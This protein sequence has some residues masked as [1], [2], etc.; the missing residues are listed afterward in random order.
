MLSTVV[1]AGIAVPAGMK[2]SGR[3]PL[4]TKRPPLVAVALVVA[5]TT[6]R[7]SITYGVPPASV[8]GDESS[9]SDVFEPIAVISYQVEICVE[10]VEPNPMRFPTH[11]P[12]VCHVVPVPVTVVP[13]TATV[14]AVCL[15]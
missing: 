7:S 8:P 5:A 14:P 2:I 9:V 11:A 4:A 13:L 3:R 1:A 15:S 12:S 6:R 10:S